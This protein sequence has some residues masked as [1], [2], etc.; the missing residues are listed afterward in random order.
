MDPRFKATKI[1]NH[2][3]QAELLESKLILWFLE[4]KDMYQK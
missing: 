1:I 3:I 2:K 4:K